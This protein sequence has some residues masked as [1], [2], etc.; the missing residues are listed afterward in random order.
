MPGCSTDIEL[1]SDCSSLAPIEA[2]H[3]QQDVPLSSPLQNS[4]PIAAEAVII[5]RPC[6]ID[7]GVPVREAASV[8]YGATRL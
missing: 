8:G 2:F 7:P 4:S 1:T 6:P 5:A 3:E